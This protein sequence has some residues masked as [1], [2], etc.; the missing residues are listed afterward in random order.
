MAAEEIQVGVSAGAWIIAAI[1]LLILPIHWFAA[2]VLSALVHELW[3]LSALMLLRV[4]LCNI[5]VG[6][7]GARIMTQP[8]TSRQEGACAL[9]G[10]VGSLSLL[11]FIRWIPL[12]A[13]CGLFQALYNL[14]PLKNLDGGR[15]LKSLCTMFLREKGAA[16]LCEIAHVCTVIIVV[17]FFLAVA[18][19][20]RLRLLPVIA[21]ILLIAAKI[22]LQRG[23]SSG[24]I[25]LPMK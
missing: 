20:V 11:L 10:P 4:R 6:A 12:T 14:L 25:V 17:V 5:S 24:T 7:F 15:V 19:I 18:V 3:H 23:R 21:V 2:I 8:M 1:M 22:F 13:L 16:R 9:A